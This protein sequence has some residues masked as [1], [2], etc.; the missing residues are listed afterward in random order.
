MR[1][2]IIKRGR[3]YSVVLE[4]ERDANGER[5]REWHSGYR[6]KREAEEARIRLLSAIQRGE[7]AE[8]SRLTLGEFLRDRWLPAMRTRVRPSTFSS[9]ERN[10]R[11]HVVPALGV[12]PL[13]RVSA[14]CSPACTPTSSSTDAATATVSPAAPSATCTRS[15]GGHSRTRVDGVS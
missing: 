5:R 8:P 7:H 1:G 4:R 2:T 3:T 9:Y 10:V 6:T 14:T 15:S 11:A 13:Q 12:V